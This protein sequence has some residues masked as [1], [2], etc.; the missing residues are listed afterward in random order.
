MNLDAVLVSVTV[1]AHHKGAVHPPGHGKDTVHPLVIVQG[2][3][4][5]CADVLR[6]PRHTTGSDTGSC[7]D[8]A[9]SN[10]RGTTRAS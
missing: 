2:K 10:D 4:L 8:S 7:E 6:S 3:D 1:C 5:E 9:S